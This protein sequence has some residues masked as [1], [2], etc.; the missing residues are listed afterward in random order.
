MSAVWVSGP[1]VGLLWKHLAG[2]TFNIHAH[3][4]VIHPCLFSSN[5]A[6]LQTHSP[7]LQRHASSSTLEYM[8]AHQ[9]D[10][11]KQR[12]QRLSCEKA[13]LAGGKSRGE[14]G[15]LVQMMSVMR[16]HSS[17]RR[18]LISHLNPALCAH[19][20]YTHTHIESMRKRE[21]QRKWKTRRSR[22]LGGL[23]NPSSQFTPTH[24][25]TCNSYLAQWN[26]MERNDWE[27]ISF[28][29]LI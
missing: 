26:Q 22:H 21:P 25:H 27:D 19:V 20:E 1:P 24:T 13:R 11:D 17:H 29:C 2:N 16:F 18:W 14:S 4:F 6:T 9:L 5:M 10:A 15:R 3:L 8:R 12:A 7:S 23:R 28:F